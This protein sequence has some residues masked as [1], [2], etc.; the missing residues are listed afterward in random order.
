MIDRWFSERACPWLTL[1]V[2]GMVAVLRV[3][4]LVAGLGLEL[5]PDEAHYWDW[6]RN[7]DWSYYSKGP[8]VAW[9]IAASTA[10]L[11]PLSETLTGHLTFAIRAPAVLCGSLLLGSLYVLSVQV[12]GNRRLGFLVVL[13][14]LSHP[15]ITAGSSLMTIDSPY[16]CAWGWASVL[17]LHAI[18]T[19]TLWAWLG[20]GVLVGLGILAKYTMVVFLPSVALFLLLCPRQRRLFFMPGP[21]LMVAVASLAA[22]PIVI[23]N[24]H[25][26][27]VTFQHVAQLAGLKPRDPDLPS[28]TI[29]WL[30]PLKY[31]GG[32]FILML[33][34]WFLLWAVAVFRFAPWHDR[35]EGRRY[36]WCLSV[37][38]FLL[39]LGFSPKTGGGELNW[40]IT[41]YLTGSVLAA[42]AYAQHGR[43]WMHGIIAATCLLG[44]L[45]SVAIYVSPA[46]HPAMERIVGKPS[47]KNPTPIR[48]LDP[49]C[50]LRGWRELAA[51]IDDIREQLRQRGE[52]PIL[53]AT[54]W[55]LPGQ[56]GVYCRDHPRVYCIGSLQ[57]ERLSQYDLWH[58]PLDHPEGFLDRTFILVGSV[59]HDTLR[60]FRDVEPA[61]IV[62]VQVGQRPIAEFTIWVARGFQGFPPR[63]TIKH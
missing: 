35:D 7:L 8:L 49:T 13:G 9:I 3:V 47:T 45:A 33:G 40:P 62:R 44:I 56:L 26:E 54:G 21:W 22:I 48:K 2:I 28:K 27:W 11:G 14:A 58:N 15:I 34:T 23:W 63:A 31:M 18:R 43:A 5:S 55:T 20:A 4:L 42:I 38:M 36:L 53:V 59:H 1:F 52:E 51:A 32:Q 29:D 10:L 6:S 24:A 41:A 16:A 30:G 19:G 60:A 37:P 61:R 39:F 57:G 17:V 12:S 50:R 25:Q 46:L